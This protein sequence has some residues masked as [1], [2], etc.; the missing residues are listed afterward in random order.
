LKEHLKILSQSQYTTVP[1]CLHLVTQFQDCSFIDVT[2]SLIVKKW[3]LQRHS[4]L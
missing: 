2:E 4:V 1:V 3:E